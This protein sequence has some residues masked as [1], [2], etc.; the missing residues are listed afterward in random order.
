MMALWGPPGFT[1]HENLSAQCHVQEGPKL[2]SRQDEELQNYATQ[3][4]N[5]FVWEEALVR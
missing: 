4:L 3:T 2:D 5:T 1:T